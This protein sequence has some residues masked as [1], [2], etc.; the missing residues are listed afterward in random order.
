[1]Y[2]F[3]SFSFFPNYFNVVRYVLLFWAVLLT[4]CLQTSDMGPSKKYFAF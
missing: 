2:V 1:M 4:V 3:V